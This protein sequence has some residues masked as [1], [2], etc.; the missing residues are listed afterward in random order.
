VGPT[1]LSIKVKAIVENITI[2]VDELSKGTEE[3]ILNMRQNLEQG[4]IVV[5][6]ILKVLS[7]TKSSHSTI[8]TTSLAKPPNFV[9]YYKAQF[10]QYIS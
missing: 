2:E 3:I 7:T 10:K 8:T 5:A 6:E 4:R 9:K 1:H